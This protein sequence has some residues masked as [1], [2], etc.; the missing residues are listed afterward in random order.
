MERYEIAVERSGVY[1]MLLLEMSP[2]SARK[3][4]T[5]LLVHSGA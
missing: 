2:G 3:G 5:S 4:T 1:G